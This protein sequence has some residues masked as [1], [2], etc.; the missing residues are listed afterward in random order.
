MCFQAEVFS[1]QEGMAHLG[2]D[3]DLI[4]RS[5]FPNS[6]FCLGPLLGQLP[7]QPRMTG[8]F[9]ELPATF[10]SPTRATNMSAGRYIVA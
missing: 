9:S 8:S 5:V 2:G 1:Q 10:M 4:A 6:L 7:T 3:L